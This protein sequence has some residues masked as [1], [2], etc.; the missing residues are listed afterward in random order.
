MPVDSDKVGAGGSAVPIC[1]LSSL[2]EIEVPSE[3][4]ASRWRHSFEDG[5]FID[6]LLINKASDTL[7]V[8]FHGA[9]NRANYTLP[10]FERIATL[11]QTEYSSLYIADPALWLD[12]SLQ[13][14]WYTGWKDLKL[15]QLLASLIHNISN[16]LKIK[17]LI[18]S[19]SSGGGYASLQVSSHL[20]GSYALAFNPQTHIHGYHDSGKPTD[21]GAVRKYIEV[22]YPQAA[23]HGIWK[24]DFN[25]DWTQSLDDRY[26]PIRRYSN[27]HE[28]VVVY[29]NNLN[30][31][32]VEQHYEPFR[33]AMRESES[34][35]NLHTFNYEG[36]PGHHP[37]TSTQFLDALKFTIE[38][39]RSNASE[40]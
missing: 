24:I 6:A 2:S 20:P 40:K 36:K 32:H 34:V 38:L 18:L 12:E 3:T 25:V 1:E 29:C 27:P 19:G 33:Q 7:V 14:A 15:D 39:A 35:T 16:Q 26:S 37:P 17:N 5:T 23:P 13:L 10:R 30:D 4:G 28:N 31:W 8:S 21:N 9:L 22:L 11:N